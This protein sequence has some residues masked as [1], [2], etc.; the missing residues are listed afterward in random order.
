M[1]GLPCARL[2]IF[3]GAGYDGHDNGCGLRCAGR[4]R[5]PD[6][7]GLTAKERARNR[8]PEAPALVKR[9]T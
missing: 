3:N 1:L 9:Q 4:M 7:G 6:G 2:E 5:Y 8:R